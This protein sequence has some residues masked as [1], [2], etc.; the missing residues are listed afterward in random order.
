MPTLWLLVVGFLPLAHLYVKMHAVKLTPDLF[1]S[2]Y[3]L[4][5][6]HFTCIGI[7]NA[8]MNHSTNGEMGRQKFL[9]QVHAA[10]E[11]HS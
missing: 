1:F 9:G 3:L 2:L 11:W 4:C 5:A 8:H 7:F 6:Q 10:R